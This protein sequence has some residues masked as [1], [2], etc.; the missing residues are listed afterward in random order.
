MR[1]R[2]RMSLATSNVVPTGAVIS[3]ALVMNSPTGLA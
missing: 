3:P 1:Y 2:R